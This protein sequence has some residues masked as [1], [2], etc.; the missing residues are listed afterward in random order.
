MVLRPGSICVPHAISAWSTAE[1]L[2]SPNI[3]KS[4]PGRF[5]K[6]MSVVAGILKVDQIG[7]AWNRSKT[8]LKKGISDYLVRDDLV[9]LQSIFI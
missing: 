8:G 4:S 7:C 9:C 1:A 6:A 3:P 5:P 2:R